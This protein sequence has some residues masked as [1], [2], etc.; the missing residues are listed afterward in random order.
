MSLIS[1]QNISYKVSANNANS[2]YILKDIS[3]E[4]NPSTI[5][6]FIGVNGGGKTTLAKILIGS[7]SPSSGK[8]LMTKNLKIGYVPQEIEIEKTIPIDVLNFIKIFAPN[9]QKNPKFYE[10]CKRLNIEN[11]LHKQIHQIS[12]GALQKILFLQA[13][14]DFKD[15]LVLDEP[16][17]FMDIPAIGEFYKIINEIRIKNKCAIIL[18]SHDLH[19]VMKK[20]DMIYCI[21]QHICCS[22]KPEEISVHPEYLSIFGRNLSEMEPNFCEHNIQLNKTN[23]P[24]NIGI[25]E[26]NPTQLITE[27]I[28]FYSHHH[29][30]Q[31][32]I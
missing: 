20:S 30:H 21:N 16:T 26:E 6:T 31:H 5:T 10:W 3:L 15:V 12:G 4:I 2:D 9:F 19:L 23:N 25:K 13:I 17:Q 18:I 22:G 11:I 28:G 8:V 27:E 29:N 7:I 1:L 32:K 24:E 14:C